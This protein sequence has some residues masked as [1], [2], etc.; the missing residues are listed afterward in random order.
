MEDQAR[1][2]APAAE[3]HARPGG[4]LCRPAGA[5]ITT[6][7]RAATRIATDT[8]A[9]AVGTDTDSA[10]RAAP[11]TPSAAATCDEAGCEDREGDESFVALVHLRLSS[12]GASHRT[13]VG[14]GLPSWMI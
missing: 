7:T 9:T 12:K 10:R 3:L 14:R 5:R 4:G 13:H 1:D 2:V 11:S 8:R 6:A